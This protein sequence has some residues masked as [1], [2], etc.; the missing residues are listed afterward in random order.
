MSPANT[1]AA[2]PVRTN[3][4]GANTVAEPSPADIPPASAAQPTPSAPPD[5][6]I[7]AHWEDAAEGPTLVVTPS[8]AARAAVGSFQAGV[9]GWDQ[10]VSRYPDPRLDEAASRMRY[11]YICH[12]QFATIDEPDKPTWDL[13][14]DRPDVGYTET[15]AARC[16]P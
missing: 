9:D 8:E 12:Q 6:I 4:A 7:E 1:P 3:T 16:N 11:Q 15:V 13:E 2:A 14:L 10:L 5:Y